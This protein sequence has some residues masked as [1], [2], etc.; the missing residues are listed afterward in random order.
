MLWSR[1]LSRDLVSYHIQ[2]HF[3]KSTNCTCLSPCSWRLTF[4]IDQTLHPSSYL[5]GFTSPPSSPPLPLYNYW[6]VG[7][8][9]LFQIK[10]LVGTRKA[11]WPSV[12]LAGCSKYGHYGKST[13]WFI[14]YL[15][16]DLVGWLI[17]SLWEKSE[18]LR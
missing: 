13:S 7:Y 10:P 11:W 6:A 9:S 5:L 4:L 16:M 18:A 15:H 2:Q 8:T 17:W 1:D 12:R 14:V 3:T